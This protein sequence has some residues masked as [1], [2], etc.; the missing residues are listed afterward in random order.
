MKTRDDIEPLYKT[1]NNIHKVAEYAFWVNSFAAIC[2]IIS[3]TVIT[4]F[5]VAVQI[6][7]TI[8]VA[9]DEA[10]GSGYFWYQAESLRRLN[11]IENAFNVDL[12]EKKA[13]GY[14]SNSASPSIVRYALNTYESAY[15]SHH[16]AKKM[17]PYLILKGAVVLALFVISLRI[18][19]NIAVPLIIAQTIFSSVIFVDIVLFLFFYSRT[20]KL[21]SNFYTYFISDGETINDRREILLLSYAVEYESIKSFHKVHLSEKVFQKEKEHLETVWATISEKIK[22]QI[23]PRGVSQ[24]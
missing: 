16:I 20:G 21:C 4:Q 24:L 10:F 18:V 9:I 6:I 19:K 22:H 13:E 7:C 2:I 1:P 12:S 8:I 15:Y 11:C 23:V 14:Y 5:A 3:P 17:L